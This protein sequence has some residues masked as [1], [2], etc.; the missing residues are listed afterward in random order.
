MVTIR[1]KACKPVIKW[2]EHETLTILAP[3]CRRPSILKY[4]EENA[5]DGSTRE[6][7]DWRDPLQIQVRITVTNRIMEK[8]T[9]EIIN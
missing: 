4:S 8:D 1:R 6:H 5:E 7:G 9:Y 2:F 3:L